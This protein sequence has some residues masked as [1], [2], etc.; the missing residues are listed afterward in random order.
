MQ[1]STL[2]LFVNC[3]T[4]EQMP[5]E[6]LATHRADRHNIA[7]FLYGIPKRYERHDK[8]HILKINSQTVRTALL[9]LMPKKDTHHHSRKCKRG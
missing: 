1:H 8:T 6:R 7:H 2:I 4:Q 9:M 5:A 3:M